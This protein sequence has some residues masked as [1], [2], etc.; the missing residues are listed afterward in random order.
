MSRL[1]HKTQ[2]GV[3]IFDLVLGVDSCHSGDDIGQTTLEF[4]AIHSLALLMLVFALHPLT[5]HPERWERR[6]T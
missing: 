5:T 2:A 4:F 6:F 3:Q 1:A